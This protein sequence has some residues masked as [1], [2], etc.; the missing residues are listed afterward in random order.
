VSIARALL[1]DP[2]ALLLDEPLAHLDPELRR[3]VR[4]EIAGVRQRFSG[5]IVYVTHDHEEALAIADRIAVLMDG[6]IE[7]AGDPQRVYD[8]PRSIAVAK[9][10][11]ARPMN[12][13]DANGPCGIRPE[14][15][16]VGPDGSLP[17]H[18]VRRE[19]TGAD[20]Y[21]TIDTARGRIV[22]RVLPETI[23]EPGDDVKLELP[24]RFVVRFDE[25]NA[26]AA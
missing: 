24:E 8:A 1:S 13:F 14:R 20:V 10:F 17:G 25:T 22:A 7:D 12:V 3:S 21:L 19:R 23:G 15:V 5:P 6:R 18:V 26:S 2:A 11:G 16:V 9:F 4:D